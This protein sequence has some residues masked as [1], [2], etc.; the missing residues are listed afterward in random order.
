MLELKCI[1]GCVAGILEVLFSL[2]NSRSMLSAPSK[3]VEGNRLLFRVV[4][5][6]KR[7][8]DNLL[9][10]LATEVKK[11]RMHL[12]ATPYTFERQVDSFWRL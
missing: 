1:Q 11:V 9:Y 4:A 7:K 2:T 10:I 3:V 5:P 6:M 8:K 12:F